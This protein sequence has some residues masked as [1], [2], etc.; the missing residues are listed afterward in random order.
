M[1][2]TVTE[3]ELPRQLGFLPKLAQNKVPCLS[4]PSLFFILPHRACATHWTPFCFTGAEEEHPHQVGALEGHK[5][6]VEFLIDKGADKD[7]TDKYG[8]T[9]LQL[10]STEEIKKLF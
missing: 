5:E 2:F 10:A 7:A 9:P 1:D 4:N 3:E 6:I 8:Q